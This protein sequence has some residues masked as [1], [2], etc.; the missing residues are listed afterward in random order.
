VKNYHKSNG[1]YAF[2][3]EAGAAA[4]SFFLTFAH[5]GPEEVTTTEDKDKGRLSA[6][7]RQSSGNKKRSRP[8]EIL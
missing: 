5:G 2:I 3:L 8:L 1:S 7:A 4:N 6:G